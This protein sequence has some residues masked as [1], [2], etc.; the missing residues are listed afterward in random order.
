MDPQLL[1][2]IVLVAT[3]ITFVLDLLPIDVTALACLA[4]LVAC[5]LV[6]P[7]EAAAGF[8][9]PAVVTVMMMFVLSDA[10]VR[11]GLIAKAAHRLAAVAGGSHWPAAITLLL[12][13]GV[14]SAFINNVAALSIFL[15]VMLH[16]AKVY[17]ISPSRLLL[18]L[19]YATI[20][21]GA[22]TLI[23]TSSNLLVSSL[24]AEMGFEPIAMFELAGLG[25]I[26]FGVGL[27]YTILVPM[28]TLPARGDEQ[29][30]MRKYRMSDFVT[31]VKIP[32]GSR[33]IGQTV[34]EANISERFGVNV[35]E[36]VRQGQHIA[37]DLRNLTL[38]VGD[39]LIVRATMEDIVALR[40]AYGLLLLTDLK[41]ADEDL[42]AAD[43]ML[44]EVQLAPTSRLL[45]ETIKQLDFRRRFGCFVLALSR[46][47]ETIRKKV[48]AVP[49][50]AWDTLLIFGPRA[51]V[52]ALEQQSDFMP[53][54]ELELKL[55]LA[56]RWWLPPAAL[57]GAVALATTG[58]MSILEASIVAVA[59]LL[60]LRV[61]TVQQAYS[62]INWSVIFLVAAILPLGTAMVNTG[63]AA[64]IGEGIATVG[65]DLGPH[66][67]IALL[68][69]ATAILTEILSNNSTA[70]LMLPIAV[71]TAVG[72]GLDPRP[73]VMTVTFA[74]SASFLTPM[75]YKTNAMVYGPGGYRF[76]DYLRAGLPLK[77]ALWLLTSLLLPFFFPLQ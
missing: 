34:L 16:L 40:E 64:R 59:V 23:G 22:C 29:S 46:T 7:T 74:A 66:I 30:L 76:L 2:I 75:G 48:T 68:Y 71:S 51:K 31:E 55:R 45:G 44:A 35:L 42:D 43:T 15:P 27:V 77:I 33:L 39:L 25:L 6:T 62:A 56:P 24:V 13:A 50:Q 26:I 52:E 60:V 5:D 53:L 49:L 4:A 12:L 61:I 19:S 36:V 54:Q 41:L 63:L 57:I 21:G 58:V 11:S 14:L 47:G 38:A 69:A 1:L 3:I 20:F 37:S 8:G 17:K 70:V 32:A 18:P 10:L 65:A 73:F 28:R 72:L 67:V 9:N